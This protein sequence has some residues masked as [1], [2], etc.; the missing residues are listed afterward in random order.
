MVEGEKGKTA[1]W[2]KSSTRFS[3]EL[4]VFE[5]GG[6]TVRLQNRNWG[7]QEKKPIKRGFRLCFLTWPEE[8]T[9]AQHV[10]RQYPLLR[11]KGEK[12]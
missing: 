7:F 4:S 10:E 5:R 9:F 1:N 8:K 3:E 12:T 6:G 11:W 2:V